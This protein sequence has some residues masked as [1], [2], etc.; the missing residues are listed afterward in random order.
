MPDKPFR[1]IL[2]VLKEADDIVKWINSSKWLAAWICIL[3]AVA[4][5]GLQPDTAHAN[6]TGVTQ[7]TYGTEVNQALNGLDV[8]NAE[9]S[10]SATASTAITNGA[11]WK[12]TAGNPIQANSGNILKVGSTYYW[13]GEHA[14]NW[15]FEK[16][17][18]YTSTDLKNWSF[19]SS[20]LTKDSALS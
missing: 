11:D 8:A 10:L 18:V 15:K 16:V 5:A 3:F 6:T 7:A 1:P 9:L 17:N 4:S 2:S 13:Y 20:I 12:D 19:R 14:E